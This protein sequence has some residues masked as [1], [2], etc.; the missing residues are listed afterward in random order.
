MTSSTPGLPST[1]LATSRSAGSKPGRLLFA[2]DFH[3]VEHHR[4][5]LRHEV[6][7][8]Q[9]PQGVVAAL[10]MGEGDTECPLRITPAAFHDDIDVRQF[11]AF[12]GEGLAPQNPID[13]QTVHLRILLYVCRGTN[14]GSHERRGQP[15]VL[16]ESSNPDTIE[17]PIRT[18]T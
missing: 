2:L 9:R 6:G 13:R 3:L 16:F 4:G 1:A 5:R 11:V 17:T 14:H 15:S 12:A 8:N 7:R 10:P 18:A